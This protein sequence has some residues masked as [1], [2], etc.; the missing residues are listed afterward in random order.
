MRTRRQTIPAEIQGFFR[1]GGLGADF[2]G[3]VSRLYLTATLNEY[4]F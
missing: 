4:D 3:G 1:D 2:R